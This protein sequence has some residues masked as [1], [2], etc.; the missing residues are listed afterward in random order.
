MKASKGVDAMGGLAETFYYFLLFSQL[1]RH[2]LIVR[3]EE[4]LLKV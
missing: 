1:K 4:E 2:K 3:T